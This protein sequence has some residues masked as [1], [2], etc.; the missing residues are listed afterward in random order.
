MAASIRRDPQTWPPSAPEA[1]CRC[2]SEWTGT[3]LRWSPA[4]DPGEVETLKTYA[5]GSCENTV[6]HYT[7]AA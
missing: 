5:V 3:K 2:L 1:L 4:A 7:A 6:V